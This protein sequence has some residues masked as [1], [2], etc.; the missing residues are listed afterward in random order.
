MTD[1]AADAI[2]AADG[3]FDLTVS[4]LVLN[5]VPDPGAGLAE[6]RRVTRRAGRSPSWRPPWPASPR[7][8]ASSPWRSADDAA[9]S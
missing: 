6:M 5:F 8:W 1:R 4:A 7:R 2:P 3:E 9:G